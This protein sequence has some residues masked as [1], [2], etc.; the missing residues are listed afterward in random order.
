LVFSN[1]TVCDVAG[2][3][4]HHRPDFAGPAHHHLFRRR[5]CTS[6]TGA[7]AKP[8]PQVPLTQERAGSATCRSSRYHCFQFWRQTRQRIEGADCWLRLRG[9]SAFRGCPWGRA[10]ETPVSPT[11][12]GM[13]LGLMHAFPPSFVFG[14]GH[15]GCRCPCHAPLQNK[16]RQSQRKF[17]CLT[18]VR[19][20]P[21]AHSLSR[22]CLVLTCALRV[23][24]DHPAS[25]G[26]VAL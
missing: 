8:G 9:S 18:R 12:G 2:S 5:E 22:E 25:R 23:V 13:P 17:A 1:A 7:A 3:G 4:C 21:A 20:E 16:E 11:Q 14:V 19:A 10:F 24:T 6:Q 26:L 15:S